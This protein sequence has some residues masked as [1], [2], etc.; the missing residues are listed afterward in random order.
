M[1]PSDAILTSSAKTAQSSFLPIRNDI[2]I[3]SVSIEIE[4]KLAS[5]LNQ[6]SKN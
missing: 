6:L 4:N 2:P 3:M 5:I 1:I